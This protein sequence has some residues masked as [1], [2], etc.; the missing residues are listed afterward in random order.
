MEIIEIPGYTQEDK[1]PI[2]S[3]HLVPKQLRLHGLN[4]EQVRF[5]ED[6]L[7]YIGRR[8]INFPKIKNKILI[9]PYSMFSKFPNLHAR[10]EFG[11]WSAR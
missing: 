3:E 9:F 5:T 8:E 7:K 10:L 1:V 6:G 4:K 11:L 2:A